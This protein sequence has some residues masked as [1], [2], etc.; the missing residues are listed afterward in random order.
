MVV[1]HA[2]WYEIYNKITYTLA[3][4]I[5]SA[6]IQCP[7]TSLFYHGI[8]VI[9]GVIQ[10]YLRKQFFKS[11]TS[12]LNSAT[13]SFTAVTASA[14]SGVTATDENDFLFFING[15]YMEHDAIAVEQSGSSFLLKV[16][17][18]S[19][20]YSLESDDEVISVGKFNS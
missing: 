18:S 14:P 1:K 11:S 19:I 20:G 10:R 13:A 16:D 9:Y 4:I 15:Q 6:M 5:S 12:I 3:K 17:E 2:V 7:L 8:I